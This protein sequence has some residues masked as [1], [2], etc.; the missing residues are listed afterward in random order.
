LDLRER[1]EEEDGEN[2]IRRNS[3][4]VLFAVCYYSN[5]MKENSVSS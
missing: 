2:H 4:I 5:K 3:I 1:K